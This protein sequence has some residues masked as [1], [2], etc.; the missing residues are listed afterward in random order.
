MLNIQFDCLYPT[1]GSQ[2]VVGEDLEP[3]SQRLHLLLHPELK[4]GET[5]LDDSELI[6]RFKSQNMASLADMHFSQAVASTQKP[7]PNEVDESNNVDHSCISRD[8]TN[9]QRILR[10]AESES[11]AGAC[12]SELVCPSGC[13]IIDLQLKSRSLS[14]SRSLSP[15]PAFRAVNKVLEIKTNCCSKTN[16]FSV[17]ENENQ[18]NTSIDAP[19]FPAHLGKGDQSTD[20]TKTNEIQ[21]KQAVER[22]IFGDGDREESVLIASNIQ[23]RK[24]TAQKRNCSKVLDEPTDKIRRISFESCSTDSII[25]I[26]AENLYQEMDQESEK[27]SVIILDTLSQDLEQQ[28]CAVEAEVLAKKYLHNLKDKHITPCIIEIEPEDQEMDQKS[29]QESQSVVILDSLS[30]ED[31]EKIFCAVEEAHRK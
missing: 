17:F 14:I 3:K 11:S 10:P 31:L 13:P 23:G 8:I 4:E 2:Q 5:N 18:L 21:R 7:F 1:S 19:L 24:S 9:A 20:S 16:D 12:N 26:E 29:H 25:E 22:V 6:S 27:E 28:F 30:F 15:H